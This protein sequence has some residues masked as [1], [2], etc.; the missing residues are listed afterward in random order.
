MIKVATLNDKL[1]FDNK[2]EIVEYFNSNILEEGQAYFDDNNYYINIEGEVIKTVEDWQD[3]KVSFG[4]CFHG[5]V[6]QLEEMVGEEYTLLDM[7]NEVQENIGAVGQDKNSIFEGE[8]EEFIK[9]GEYTYSLEDGIKTKFLNVKFKVLRDY[10][11][12]MEVLV[13]VTEIEVL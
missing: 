8:T 5:V 10:S 3:W 6:S 12:K 2:D 13:E 1:S 7:D 9:R 4:D 11:I